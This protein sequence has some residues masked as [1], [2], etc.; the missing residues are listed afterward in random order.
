M[1]EEAAVQVES[2]AA[3]LIESDLD[4]VRELKEAGGD[5]LKKCFQCATCSVVC[6]LAPEQKPYPRKEMIY[7]QWG[8]KDK[9]VNS[10]DVW[11]CHYCNDCS[12]HC[13]RGARPGDTLRAIRAIS[14]RH[15]AFPNFMGK[16][17]G[18]AKYLPVMLALPVLILLL[19]IKIAG[20]HIPAGP[21]EYRDLF[22]LLLVDVIFITFTMLAL[23]SIGF[24]VWNFLQ[25][26]HANA[27][28][29]G[30]AEDKPLVMG[31]YVKSL[32][33]VIPTILFH[34]KF[35]LCIT[36]RDRYWSHLLV[37][38]GFV[39]L[40]IVT[41]IGFIGIYGGPLLGI[42][43][44]FL[45]PP[46][47]FGNPIKLFALVVGISLLVGIILVITNRLK[48]KAAEST[49]TYL[50]WSLIIAVLLTAAT[51]LL[52]WLG[53]VANAGTIAYV[54]YFVHLASV[55]YIIA[56]LPYSKL[57]HLVYRTVAMGYAAH[58]DR[59]FGVEVAEAA[60]VA[61][62][63]AEP[64][65]SAE[66]APAE[67]PAA[68]ETAVEKAAAEAEPAEEKTEAP[69]AEEEEEKKE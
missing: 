37:F 20:G 15:F 2:K 26:I 6:V 34:N 25:G 69:T 19:G 3:T 47:S 53:R 44:S 46:Y 9:L 14:F 39:G 24:G 52:T 31:D 28:K 11:L 51:G 65:P 49:I 1:A 12:A 45:A 67:E 42:D 64:T 16:I 62:P 41:N 10:V 63:A 48:T 29:E 8:L 59:P 54:I 4:F 33:S 55:F 36:N 21:V 38:V 17:V 50:D 32:I 35:K 5:T 57:A 13:P 23:L 22:P 68:E 40:F 56:Y 18:Q 58:I 27:V 7:S 66:E 43:T 30:Y 60:P 61:A